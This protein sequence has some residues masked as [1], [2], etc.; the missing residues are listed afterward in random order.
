MHLPQGQRTPRELRAI[1]G[2]SE[3]VLAAFYLLQPPCLRPLPGIAASLTQPALSVG[4]EAG[5]QRVSEQ[6]D[7]FSGIGEPVNRI[8]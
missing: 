7:S 3:T 2:G 8:S 1:C 5:Q 6:Q 4:R